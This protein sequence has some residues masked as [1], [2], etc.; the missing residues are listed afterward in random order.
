METAPNGSSLGARLKWVREE[1]LGLKLREM[2]KRLT[3]EGQAVTHVTVAR[4]EDN[5]KDG[6]V[7]GA[8][9]VQAVAKLAGVDGGWLLTGAGSPD[10]DGGR[11]W[12][13]DML[14]VVRY[15]QGEHPMD[16][17]E[18]RRVQL[19]MLT[20]MIRLG[21]DEGR[22]VGKLVALR[23]QLRDGD[24]PAAPAPPAPQPEAVESETEREFWRRVDAMESDP[25]L[26]PVVKAVRFE[27]LLAAR[28][29]GI[30]ER[31]TLIAEMR[32]R[33]LEKETDQGDARTRAIDEEVRNSTVRTL[34]LRGDKPAPPTREEAL[35]SDALTEGVIP[36][37][38]PTRREVRRA[39]GDK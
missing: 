38:A 3:E 4:Y 8:D 32:V 19:D 9:Y 1:R 6:R 29:I 37:E 31:E 2:A 22:D 14:N 7:P 34:A 36:D 24:A 20:G 15:V 16:D 39:G 26:S 5:G 10:G 33:T 35:E 30:H 27:G 13:D 17:A 11:G 25:A 12:A 18:R 28:R 21:R 23:D